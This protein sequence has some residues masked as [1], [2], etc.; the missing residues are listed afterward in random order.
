MNHRLTRAL[1]LCLALAAVPAMP[2]SAAPNTDR[3][4]IQAKAEQ[5]AFKFNAA[6]VSLEAAVKVAP[7]DY[8]TRMA[9]GKL[10]NL[11]GEHEEALEQF[12]KCLSL[13]EDDFAAQVMIAR[14]YL[15]LEKY[16]KSR[17]LCEKLENHSGRKEAA[18][19]F[20]SALYNTL[21]G[22]LGLKSKREGLFAMLQ[23]GLRVRKELEKAVDID[24]ENPTAQY[25]LGRY[26]LEAPGAVGGD[27]KRGT[28]M[29]A[30]ASKMEPDDYPIRGWYVRA[31]F[32][33]NSPDAKDEAERYL[34]D[35]AELPESR[36]DFSD[37]VAKAK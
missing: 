13:K 17:E 14:C 26:F 28:T 6:R 22:S 21:G 15:L 35:F 24:P 18:S 7:N 9:F 27:S 30:K 19:W 20:R 37:I 10:L 8:E 5:K 36:K 32:Q 34:K 16:D 23:Y 4:M 11:R 1:A 25:S 29:L 2:V 3:Y 12:T 31:L 33:T